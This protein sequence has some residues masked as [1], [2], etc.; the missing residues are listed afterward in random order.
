ME[1]REN[2]PSAL[3][4]RFAK[5]LREALGFFCA[6]LDGLSEIDVDGIDLAEGDRVEA[7]VSLVHAEQGRDGGEGELEPDYQL[8]FFHEI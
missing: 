6:E 4:C 8:K 3:M 1:Q 7:I 2:I 5:V